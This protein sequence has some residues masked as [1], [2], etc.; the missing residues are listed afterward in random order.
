MKHGIYLGFLIQFLYEVS[1]ARKKS[2]G[3][4]ITF[5]VDNF[6]LFVHCGRIIDTLIFYRLSI[7][8]EYHFIFIFVIFLLHFSILDQK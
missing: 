5:V 7:A 6:K 1:H 3:I 2:W 4:F 8:T